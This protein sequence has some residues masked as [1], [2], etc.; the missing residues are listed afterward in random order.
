MKR[1]YLI[2]APLALSVFICGIFIAGG[3]LAIFWDP[4]SVMIVFLPSLFLLLGVFGPRGIVD[5]F[6]FAFEGTAAVRVDIEKGI[7]FFAMAG[8][9]FLLSGIMGTLMGIL[10]TLFGFSQVQTIPVALYIVVAFNTMC[11]SVLM[12]LIVI[13]PF[14][15][16]LEK[17][18]AEMSA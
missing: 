18:L 1:S 16:A 13:V 7:A 12:L 3:K 17:R 2:Y 6:K 9:I 14:K 10:M 5:A 8:R 15:T 4:P 11:Y